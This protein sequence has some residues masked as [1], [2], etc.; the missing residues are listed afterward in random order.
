[1]IPLSDERAALRESDRPLGVVSA[2]GSAEAIKGTSIVLERIVQEQAVAGVQRAV[3]VFRGLSLGAATAVPANPAVRVVSSGLLGPNLDLWKRGQ[4]ELIPERVSRFPAL[5]RTGRIGCDIF[6]VRAAQTEDG[7]VVGTVSDYVPAALETAAQIVIERC[8]AMPLL[9]GA[10]LISPERVDEVIESGDPVAPFDAGAEVPEDAAIGRYVAELVEDGDCIEIGVGGPARA[11]ARALA[12]RR[13]LSIHT[14][15]IN[16]DVLDLIDSGAVTNAGSVLS[17]GRS[18]TPV[19]MGSERFYRRL[20]GRRDIVLH[21]VDATNDP[22]TVAAINRFVAINSTVEVDLLGQVNSEVVGGRRLSAPGGQTDF[23]LGSQLSRG[24]KAI[25][26]VRATARRGTRS[27]IVASLPGGM[28]T[29]PV[30]MVDY[31]V[32]EYGIASLRGMNVEERAR[33]L[34]QIAHPDFRNELLDALDH[35]PRVH[36]HL[37]A[38]PTEPD[39]RRTVESADH[40]CR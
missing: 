32:S 4:L 10:P 29:A 19:A 34:V 24:G 18:V 22:L 3:T 38:M 15:L 30:G 1:M 26:V 2:Q 9:P 23:F 35:D 21:P 36:G 7:F 20:A 39:R 5:L 8:D 25:A 27:R 16:D 33:R 12:S 11:I 14:G 37:S 6:V 13:R 40:S 17:P 31:V 28:V